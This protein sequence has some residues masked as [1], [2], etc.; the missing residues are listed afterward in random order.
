MTL[1]LTHQM[2]SLLAWPERGNIQSHS[3][4]LA[5]TSSEKLCHLSSQ[6]QPDLASA[7]EYC[8]CQWQLLTAIGRWCYRL[9]LFSQLCS[10]V[11]LLGKLFHLLLLS[12]G[13]VFSSGPLCDNFQ[14]ILFVPS[15]SP[16]A[17]RPAG[18]PTAHTWD[19]WALRKNS[20]SDTRQNTRPS[21]QSYIP[22]AH[23]VD[24]L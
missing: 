4:K 18:V 16:M 17:I 12:S 13:E 8:L 24:R 2:M 23:S 3:N 11:F 6:S 21:G 15:E 1:K 7:G 19:T 9:P 14:P 5:I 20:S 10:M 22:Y